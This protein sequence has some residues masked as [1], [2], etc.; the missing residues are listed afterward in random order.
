MVAGGSSQTTATFVQ[1][2]LSDA[3]IASGQLGIPVSAI[4]AQWI[5]ET[6]SGT[7]TGFTQQHN[8]AG[9]SLNVQVETYPD[10]KSGLVA[11]IIR[12]G[13]SVYG[14]TRTTI[15]NAGNAGAP[16]LV[17]ARAI[18]ASPWA[19]GRYGGTPQTPGHD[20]EDII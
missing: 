20:L 13:N 1:Q 14:P 8:Y 15:D 16:G 2:Y 19:V 11:Y 18:E 4:L 10:L 9:V 6:T 5:D 17:A 3:R 7:S 12:W